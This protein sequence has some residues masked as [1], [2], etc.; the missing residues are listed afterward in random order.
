MSGGDSLVNVDGQ[1]T[2][3]YKFS[4]HTT[5]LPGFEA[6]IDIHP[7]PLDWLHW[8]NSFSYVRGRFTEPVGETKNVPFIPAAKWSSEIKTSLFPKAKKVQHTT[9]TVEAVNYLK[10]N[11]PF[12]S[13][14]TETA[15]PGYTLINAGLSTEVHNSERKLFSLYLLGNNLTDAAYQ[16]HLSR[17]KYT[18]ENPVTGRMGV[19][20]MGRNFMVKL[21]VNF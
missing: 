8:E 12:T 20:N 19:F 10:Q 16:N 1:F 2:P 7:H 6:L 11:S 21:N 5:N 14:G 9:F 18:D 15:T 17:L 13:F 3:A 4:Q